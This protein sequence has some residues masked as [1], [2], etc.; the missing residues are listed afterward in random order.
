MDIAW[1]G[2]VIAFK[3]LLEVT[4]LKHHAQLVSSTLQQLVHVSQVV[5]QALM[6][7][8]SL[9]LA[10]HARVLV[11]NVQPLRLI[12]LV[13]SQSTLLLCIFTI[14][15]AMKLALPVPMPKYL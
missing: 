14:T 2:S 5:P 9:I 4:A 11:L 3:P 7:T 10:R 12:A 1:E 6:P 13:V 8:Y 15:R